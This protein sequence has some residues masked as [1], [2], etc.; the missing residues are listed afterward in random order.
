MYMVGVG[1]AYPLAG[2]LT[3]LAGVRAAYGLGVVVTSAAVLTAVCTI[4]AAPRARRAVSVDLPGAALLGAGLLALL[5]VIGQSGLWS[6]GAWR[7]LAVLAGSV[8]L[9]AAWVWRE[10][11]TRARAGGGGASIA[12][13]MAAT[14]DWSKVGDRL[15]CRDGRRRCER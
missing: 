6:E 11:R 8:L 3:D 15:S 14:A 1:I 4:P 12:T 2:L 7:A 10:R 13:P 9:L 5:L